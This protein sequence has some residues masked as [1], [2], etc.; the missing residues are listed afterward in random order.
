MVNIIKNKTLSFILNT[1]FGPGDTSFQLSGT[2][3]NLFDEPQFLGTIKGESNR[4]VQ[5][6]KT[7]RPVAFSNLLSRPVAF[8]GNIKS[9]IKEMEIENLRINL[10]N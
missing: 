5:F 7:R 9:S 1:S 6:F 4:L 8:E 2:I 10:G 3:L